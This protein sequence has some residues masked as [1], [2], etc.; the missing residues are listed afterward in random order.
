MVKKILLPVQEM[1]DVGSIPDSE[2]S[3]GEENGNLFQYSFLEDS[4]GRGAWWATVH[5]NTESDV[6]EH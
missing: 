2:R 1:Q 6:I 5:A 4:M 3:P